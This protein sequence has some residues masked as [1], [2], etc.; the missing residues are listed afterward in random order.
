MIQLDSNS[1]YVRG[2]VRS[3][4]KPTSEPAVVISLS[5]EGDF[6]SRV[7]GTPGGGAANISREETGRKAKVNFEGKNITWVWPRDRS[8]SET[9]YSLSV[10]EI[11][12][13][14]DNFSDS[15]VV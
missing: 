2:D 13:Q 4:K 1:S 10:H 11:T 6:K 7:N 14:S 15:A 12:S 9:G 3:S 5:V 8:K